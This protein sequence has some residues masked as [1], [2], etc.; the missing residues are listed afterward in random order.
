MQQV[1]GGTSLGNHVSVWR[2]FIKYWIPESG[3]QFWEEVVPLDSQSGVGY[4]P[5]MREHR[6][7]E[8]ELLGVR[9]GLQEDES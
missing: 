5:A 1:W 2:R 9:M 6:A 8:I 3:S 4:G 7:E